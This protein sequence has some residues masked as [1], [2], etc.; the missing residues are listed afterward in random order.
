MKKKN[1]PKTR[2]WNWES[3][4]KNRHCN[5]ATRASKSCWKCSRIKEWVSACF[6]YSSLPSIVERKAKQMT[7]RRPR[8]SL[9][10]SDRCDRQ[11]TQTRATPV[12]NISH[13]WLIVLVSGFSRYRQWLTRSI[14]YTISQTRPLKRPHNNNIAHTHKH[15]YKI[16][17]IRKRGGEIN[18][19]SN[20]GAGTKTGQHPLSLL[21]VY[22]FLDLI[23]V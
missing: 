20:A 14:S 21:H 17:P 13:L 23:T 7:R 6:S 5:R 9:L 19:A 4:R 1:K 16:P 8:S 10:L 18:D 2:N 22:I 15:A 11:W 3:R 12:V